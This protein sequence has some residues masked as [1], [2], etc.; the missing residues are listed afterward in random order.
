MKNIDRNNAAN[1][2]KHNQNT[3]TRLDNPV[4]AVVIP[5]FK[6]KSHIFSV[7]SQIGKEVDIIYVVDDSCP[8]MTGDY[9]LKECVDPRVQVIY[10]KKNKG[11]GGAVKSGYKQAINDGATVVV[12]LD[13]DGQMNPA[14]IPKF[15]KPILK[16]EADYVKGN[17]FF[18]LESLAQM[19]KVRIFGNAGLSF[20]NKLSS[21]YYNVMDPTNG[22]TAI[23]SICLKMM[24]FS[25]ISNRYFFESDMLFRLNIIRAVVYDLPMKS[26]YGEEISNLNIIRILF[27][28]PGKYLNRFLKRIV[29][30][31]FL[32]DF[33]VGSVEILIAFVFLVSG[34]SYGLFNW[35]QSFVTGTVAT[36]GTVMFA[37]LPIILGFQSLLAAIQYDVMHIPSKPLHKML[38]D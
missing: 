22:Y 12:K 15:I 9:V 21:G 33:N 11:V 27:D 6:V 36:S 29:Y 14:L 25:K 26:K 17:R 8:E 13:G 18:D 4:I 24:P 38:D 35:Y 37:S 30:N 7:I 3:M 1:A 23:H 28:F 5:C 34:I 19:P 16:G 10:H 20:I 2:Y 31:Y 32:R